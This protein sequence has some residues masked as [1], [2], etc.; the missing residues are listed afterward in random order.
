MKK[1]LLAGIVFAALIAFAGAAEKSEPVKSA[2]SVKTAKTA[3]KKAAKKA[4]KKVNAPT[5]EITYLCS[6]DN[7]QQPAL[8]LEAKSKEPRPLFVTLHTWSANYKQC[9]SSYAGHLV[10]H[11]VYMIAPNFRGNNTSGN[12][13]SM[14]S[15]AAVSDIIDAVKYMQKNYNIDNSRIYLIGGSGGGFMSLLTSSRSRDIWAGVSSWCPI[16]DIVK[17]HEYYSPKPGTARGYGIHIEKNIGSPQTDEN[18][19][20]EAIHRSPV[21]HLEG[22]SYPLDISHG[23]FDRVVP[24]EHAVWAFN[25]AAAPEDRFTEAEIEAIKNIHKTRKTPAGFAEVTEKFGKYKIY[26]RRTSGNVRINLFHAGHAILGGTGVQ[27]L[28]KQQKGKTADFSK[29]NSNESSA[30]LGR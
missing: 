8:V 7:T 11:D 1:S 24:V 29:I 16:S 13:L 6:Y 25:K 22:V 27:W 17:W 4:K 23:V 28:L 2:G 15:D 10:K 3:K 21:T 30:A 26:V 12:R 9:R 5:R 19:K 14:G 18:A 20:K